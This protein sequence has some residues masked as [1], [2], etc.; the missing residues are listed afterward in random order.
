MEQ[1]VSAYLTSILQ[2]ASISK[3]ERVQGKDTV[4]KMVN[5]ELIYYY[6]TWAS[7]SHSSGIVASLETALAVARTVF[8][9]SIVISDKTRLIRV[10]IWKSDLERIRK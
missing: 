6:N 10:R 7:T 5:L 2:N 1:I 3:V 9:S 4:A 8:M